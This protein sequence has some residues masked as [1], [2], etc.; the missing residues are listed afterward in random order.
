MTIQPPTITTESRA[1][2]HD[3][4]RHLHA[5]PELSMQEHATAALIDERMSALGYETFTCGGTG[6]VATLRNG[7]GPVVAFRADTDGLPV[8]ENTGLDYASTA[9]RT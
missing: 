4:Y 3:L 2:L 6:I 7:D 9:R 8:A 1:D 5:A